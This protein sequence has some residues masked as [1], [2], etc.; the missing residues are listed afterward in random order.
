MKGHS[1]PASQTSMT[2][3]QYKTSLK[4][5]S[6]FIPGSS[7]GASIYT[8]DIWLTNELHILL[9]ECERRCENPCLAECE[10]YAGPVEPWHYTIAGECVITL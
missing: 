4:H 6:P 5:K 9:L 1:F 10:V 3:T 7:R 2:S 8:E